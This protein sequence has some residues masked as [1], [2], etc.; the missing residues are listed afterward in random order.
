MSYEKITVQNS[1]YSGQNGRYSVNIIPDVE[2][3]K[4]ADR[5][6]KLHIIKPE[7]EEEKYPLIVYVKGSSWAKQKLYRN[8]PK[9]CQIA[10]YGFVIAQ[11]EYR[12]MPYGTVTEMVEDTK[13]AVRFMR[14]H[15]DEYNVDKEKVG[16]F[17][18]SS[19]GHIALMAALT[20]GEYKNGI[21]PEESDKVT[22]VVDYYGVTHL[23]S[24]AEFYKMDENHSN[25]FMHN[26]L[27]GKVDAL[28]I[29]WANPVDL[30]SAEK[31]IPPIL[32]VHGDRDSVV[33]FSQSIILAEKLEKCNKEV[34]LVKV[35]GGEHDFG[36][37]GDERAKLT[38]DF[39]N[40]YFYYKRRR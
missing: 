23:Q 17:G 6:M 24:L 26:L 21:C 18:D 7:N 15:A 12:E 22:A 16:L 2:Y 37:W 32:I 39:F 1:S 14:R 4:F 10:E 27:G 38:A 9:L 13:A 28:G 25:V 19:G 8:L 5:S 30:V 20:D 40:S 36:I 34:S 3:E 29:D 35:M 33:P 31:D 11:V